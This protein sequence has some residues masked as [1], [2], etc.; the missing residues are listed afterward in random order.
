MLIQFLN[1]PIYLKAIKE[2]KN[3]QI[4]YLEVYLSILLN[5]R[6]KHKVTFMLNDIISISK[7]AGEI[8]RKGFGT[9]LEIE[10]KTNAKNL[11]TQIDKASEELIINFIRKKVSFA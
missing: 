1:I 6:Y 11:V 3:V 2:R 4:V 8:I 5:H 9:I 10:Y 7:E